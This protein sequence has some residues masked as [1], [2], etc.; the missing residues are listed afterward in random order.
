MPLTFHH[1]SRKGYSLFAALGHE[2]RIGVLS[3]ATLATASP[4]LGAPATICSESDTLRG[5]R[6]LDEATVS[7][8][9]LVPLAADVA[10]RQVT[11][12]SRDDI[13][14]AGVTSINDLL[15]LC[16][17]VDVRQR[18]PH[19][20]Q[21]D[22]GIG[23]GTFDQ[24][25]I[26]LN[27]VNISSP[28]TG[29]LSADLP[30][31]PHDIE[32][33]EVLEG[34]A[35][36]VFGTQAFTGVINIVTKRSSRDT[37]I[38][39][40]LYAAGGQ[41][42]YANVGGSL[43]FYDQRLSANYTRADG[44]TAH[45][46]FQSTRAFFQGSLPI[47]SQRADMSIPLEGEA[48]RRGERGS[49]GALLSYSVGYS[50]KPFDANTF[51]GASS[52]DQW[53]RN[54][55]WMAA[56]GLKTAIGHVHIEPTISWNRWYDHYQWHKGSPAGENR[57]RVDTYSANLKNWVA[58]LA[59]T[60]AFGVEARNEGILSTK[61]GEK[62]DAQ[63]GDNSTDETAHFTHSANR[64][65]LSA[66]LEHN[67]VYRQW[68][69]SAGVLANLN[70]ALDH[71][72]RFYPG[73]D[74]AWRPHRHWTLSANWN[75]ALRMPTFTDLYY[76]GANIEGNRHLQP[77]RTQD[78]ALH[79]QWRRPSIMADFTGT[80]SH[81]TNMID[82]VVWADDVTNT[83]RSGNFT[84]NNFGIRANAAWLPRELWRNCPLRKLAVQYAWLNSDMT[85]PSPITASK[86]AMEYLRH[87][88]VATADGRLWN[89]LHLSLAWR[90]QQ[91]TG[92]YADAYSL[93]DARL[94]WD[95]QHPH[96]SIKGWSTYVEA[97]NIFNHQYVEYGYVKQPG[98]WVIAGVLL[99]M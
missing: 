59:G 71:R 85:Y 34:A 24:A 48:A 29:H 40:D 6:V 44:A 23:G 21:T 79:I 22:I 86:Y 63:Q 93:M 95:D 25:T 39:G 65:N 16:A 70:T 5:E 97:K 9:S 52:T 14:A 46:A 76:S 18:G 66:Y 99:R 58:W 36:R 74:L 84:L 37:K 45:S 41:Y 67:V 12:F 19:G 15:K 89:S 38:E 77:E 13:A 91:R 78:A 75:M 20:I 4:C 68:T 53:E 3:A 28:H 80:F 57:H 8:V 64:T 1:F 51:Y 73:A 81:R 32:R 90:W 54:E 87:K 35:A 47:G 31:S 69:F 26:L 49:Q 2:V 55:R 61:L 60:T 33:V 92:M 96:K 56:V 11:T 42:G 72:W 83:F 82:W 43:S 10:A 7:A 27:G 94:S 98:A 30:V 17:G 62:M 50:N 88:V